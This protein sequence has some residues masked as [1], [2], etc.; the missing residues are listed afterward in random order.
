MLILHCHVSLLQVP[1]DF[2]DKRCRVNNITTFK[3]KRS[4]R[5]SIHGRCGIE[6]WY[7][8]PDKCNIARIFYD[9]GSSFVN[10]HSTDT[11]QNI[12][13]L[14]LADILMDYSRNIPSGNF[15]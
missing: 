3:K 15:T 9:I 6:Y 14:Y 1:G 4:S 7:R 11:P 8:V 10:E 5:G 13:W 2:A 12:R